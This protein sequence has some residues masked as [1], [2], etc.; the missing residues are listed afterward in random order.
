MRLYLLRHGT[1]EPRED[2]P[3]DAERALVKKGRAQC[4][5]V[6]AALARLGPPARVLTS[7]LRRARE[8]A[9]EVIERAGLDCRL[10]EDA[11]LAPEASL[12]DALELV[13]RPGDGPLLAVGH[14][15]LLSTLAGALA[16]ARA[17]RLDLK[18]G[19]LVELELESRRPPRAVLLGLLRPGHLR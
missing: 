4:A 9:E 5:E 2:A 14:E 8:T 10:V 19:G 17:L 12:E 16:G 7:P 13:T 15:P 6:A 11:A 1:A 18:K 3:D